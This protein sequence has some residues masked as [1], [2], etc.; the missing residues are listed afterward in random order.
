[1]GSLRSR[2]AESGLALFVAF[3]YGD[4][5]PPIV[6]GR[7]PVRVEVGLTTGKIRAKGDI[8]VTKNAESFEQRVPGIREQISDS[9]AWNI[10]GRD[11]PYKA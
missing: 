8:T 3:T 5:N 2:H 1:M 9:R 4:W 10:P 11:R 6:D 7:I